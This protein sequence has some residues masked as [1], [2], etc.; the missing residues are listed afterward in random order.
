MGLSVEEGMPL[1]HDICLPNKVFIYLL[2]GIPQLL[3]STTSQRAL[4]TELADAVILG[5]MTDAVK[6]AAQLD[7]FFSNQERATRGRLSA[8]NL[9]KERFCWDVEKTILTRLLSGILPLPR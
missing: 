3:A 1:N 4:A 7:S 9:A 5:D 2:A 6:T 8:W